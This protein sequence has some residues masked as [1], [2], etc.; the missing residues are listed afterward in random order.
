MILAQGTL[1]PL[2]SQLKELRAWAD[3]SFC[4]TASKEFASHFPGFRGFTNDQLPILL[5]L[6][7]CEPHDDPFLGEEPPVRRA[8]FWLME[9]GSHRFYFGCGGKHIK[10]QPGD[11]VVFDD[12]IVHWVMSEKQWRGSASQ[13][14]PAK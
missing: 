14:R 1:T 8:I 12:S 7:N 6:K 10:M 11:F 2:K 4:T 5:K 9:G 3:E 13:L